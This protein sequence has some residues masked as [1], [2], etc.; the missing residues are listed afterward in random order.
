MM[1]F[2]LEKWIEQKF[3]DGGSS[4]DPQTRNQAL[5][6]YNTLIKKNKIKDPLP[7]AASV[8]WFNKFKKRFGIKH[9]LYQKLSY[10]D[11]LAAN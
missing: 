6:L 7:F 5:V 8:G 10:A 2:Y 4:N 11:T 3:K 1:E 9:A